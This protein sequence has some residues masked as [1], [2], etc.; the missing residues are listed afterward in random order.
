ME[1]KTLGK[2]IGVLEILTNTMMCAFLYNLAMFMPITGFLLLVYKIKNVSLLNKKKWIIVNL[3][4]LFFI[5][6]F[7]VY[8]SSENN[9]SMSFLDLNGLKNSIGYVLIFLPIEILY[10]VFNGRKKLIPVFDR[11]IISGIVA[12]AA[13]YIYSRILGIDM[14]IIKKILEDVGS[15]D[16]QLISYIMEELKNKIFYLIYIY[17]GFIIYITYYLFGKRSYPRWRISY[18]WLILY[19][20]PFYLVKFGHMENIYLINTMLIIKISFVVYGLKILYNLIRTK[21]KSNLICHILA[22]LIGLNFQN[23]TFIMAGLLS[24]QAIKITIIRK[25]GGK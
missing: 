21:I 8:L 18:Q 6:G 13:A 1:K 22:V 16:K 20:I 17:V 4:T 3:L 25:N 2:A 9:V 14:E 19:M 5:G 11:I 24:F 15:L 23:I 12:T 10:Y 7:S